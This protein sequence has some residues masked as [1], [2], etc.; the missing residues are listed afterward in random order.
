MTGPRCFWKLETTETVLLE[1][2]DGPALP[3]PGRQL[4]ESHVGLL[5]PG[6]REQMSVVLATKCVVILWHLQDAAGHGK[7]ATTLQPPSPT[8]LGVAAG[9][10]FR[11]ACAQRG[12]SEAFSPPAPCGSLRRAKQPFPLASLPTAPSPPSTPDSPGPCSA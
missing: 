9:R 4:R 6:L 7:V 5:T 11:D 1:P 8:L 2:W 12:P 3:A 10:G